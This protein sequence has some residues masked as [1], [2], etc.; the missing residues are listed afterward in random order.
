MKNPIT[1]IHEKL[2][3]YELFGKLHTDC[4]VCLLNP[5]KYERVKKCL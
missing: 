5:D 4:K 1:R 2:I 3:G